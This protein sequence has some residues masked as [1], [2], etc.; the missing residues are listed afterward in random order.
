LI[1]TTH[2]TILAATNAVTY[3]VRSTKSRDALHKSLGATQRSA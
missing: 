1:L 2:I 3:F